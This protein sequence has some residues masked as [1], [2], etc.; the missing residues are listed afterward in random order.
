MNTRI[1]ALVAGVTLAITGPAVVLANTTPHKHK[2]KHAH[3]KKHAK[4]VTE[5]VAVKDDVYGASKVKIHKGSSV[6]WVWDKNNYDSHNVTLL[7]GPKGVKKF[8]SPS[9]SVGLHYKRT[10]DKPGTYQVYCTIHPE[11]MTMTVVVKR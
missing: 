1:T 8:D 4:P 3:K 11:A 6:K 9:G 5:K 2:H 7:K 10:F